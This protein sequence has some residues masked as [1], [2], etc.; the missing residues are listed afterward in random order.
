MRTDVI[1]TTTPIANASHPTYVSIIQL[2]AGKPGDLKVNF[3]LA[4][5]QEVDS[6]LVR[7]ALEARAIEGKELVTKF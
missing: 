1:E 6:L 2:I 4:R 7:Q 3:A 5:T